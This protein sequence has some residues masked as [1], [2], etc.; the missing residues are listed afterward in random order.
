MNFRTIAL[1]ALFVTATAAGFAQTSPVPQMAQIGIAQSG[2]AFGFSSAGPVALMGG[3]LEGVTGQPF[4]AQQE[5]QTIQTLAD[6]THITGQT[7]KVTYYRD[8]QGRLRTER[9]ALTV[10][11]PGESAPPV[12]IDVQDPVGG[13]RYNFDSNS[14]TVHRM[15]ISPMRNANGGEFR[16]A[17]PAQMA[18]RVVGA[19]LVGNSPWI[20][21]SATASQRQ[22]P[23]TAADQ[24]GAR[25]IEGVLAEGVRMT[26]TWPVGFFGN[27]RPITTMTETW[28]SRD[29]GMTVLNKTSDPRSGES[30]TKLTNISRTEPDPSLFQPP[31]GSEIVD[32]PG[33]SI[34]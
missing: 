27:D 8:S 31:A 16:A 2:G 32:P 4:S 25:N 24:L 6:G 15:P 26:T 23:T 13:Y 7:Q 19:T 11:L 17:I 34:Q 10:G 9:T 22:G 1:A 12:F 20:S 30:T 21:T 14:R 28:T 33:Q 18:K 3:R 5:S 29:L